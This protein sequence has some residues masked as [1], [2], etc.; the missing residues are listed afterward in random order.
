MVIETNLPPL[1]HQIPAAARRLGI[2]RSL[3]YELVKGGEL[4]LTKLGRRSVI[5]ETELQ[6]LLARR[7]VSETEARD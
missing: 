1:A 4:H 2:S 5:T 7:T 6:A 3:I